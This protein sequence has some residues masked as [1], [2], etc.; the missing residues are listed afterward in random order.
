MEDEKANKEEVWSR[1]RFFLLIQVFQRVFRGSFV[2]GLK[3]AFQ[4][5]QLIGS[6]VAPVWSSLRVTSGKFL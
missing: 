4:R 5:G 3:S 2:A 6:S 1:P